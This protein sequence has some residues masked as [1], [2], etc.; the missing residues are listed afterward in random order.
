MVFCSII[1]CIGVGILLLILH[2]NCHVMLP[3]SATTQRCFLN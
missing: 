1:Y 3:S 2:Q